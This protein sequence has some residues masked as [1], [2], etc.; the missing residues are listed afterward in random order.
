MKKYAF[1]PFAQAEI[2]RILNNAVNDISNADVHMTELYKYLGTYQH[3]AMKHGPKAKTFTFTYE[4]LIKDY[5]KAILFYDRGILSKY[6]TVDE[7]D[8]KLMRTAMNTIAMAISAQDMSVIDSWGSYGGL[9]PEQETVKVL[10]QSYVA[11]AIEAINGSIVF[12]SLDFG[13]RGRV[14]RNLKRMR[15]AWLGEEDKDGTESYTV[16]MGGGRG[17]SIKVYDP[18]GELMWDSSNTD[19]EK[20][21]D[22]MN[23]HEDKDGLADFLIGNGIIKDGDKLSIKE[24]VQ[25]GVLY[26]RKT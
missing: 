25:E 12:E 16:D 21:M 17:D 19:G 14:K 10:A 4:Q 5:H 6:P 3:E 1:F 22:Y 24:T 26:R 9:T 18:S 11:Q 20:L 23:G 2:H 8:Y 13:K 7:H 15:S